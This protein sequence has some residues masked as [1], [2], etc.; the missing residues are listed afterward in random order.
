MSKNLNFAREISRGGRG[1]TRVGG[2][3]KNARFHGL[4]DSEIY[5]TEYIYSL[6][7]IARILPPVWPRTGAR[8]V[9]SRILAR[10]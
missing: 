7:G 2:A 6:A 3:T 4:P 9:V 1:R 8:E 5:T 10:V